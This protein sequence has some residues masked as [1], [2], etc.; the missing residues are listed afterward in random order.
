MPI[1]DELLRILCCPLTKKPVQM[2]D[3]GKL[4]LLN[5]QI[6]SGTIADKEGNAITEPLTEGIITEDS[7]TIYRIDENIPVMLTE[8]GIATDQIEGF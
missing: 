6:A 4:D 1:S 8:T 5:K 3:A 2:L 7:M